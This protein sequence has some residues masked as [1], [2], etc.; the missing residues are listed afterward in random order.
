[1]GNVPL[2]IYSARVRA[3]GLGEVF[4]SGSFNVSADRTIT[5]AIGGNQAL[6]PIFGTVYATGT[7]TAVADAFVEI[8]DRDKRQV[9]GT[10]TN[11]GGIFEIRAPL[12]TNFELT[13]R[14]P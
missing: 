4:H 14:K 7:T 1:M 3:A 5:I 12:G 6:L 13:V 8:R 11:S 9:F 2:G 10:K